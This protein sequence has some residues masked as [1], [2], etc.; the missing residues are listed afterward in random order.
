[1]LLNNDWKTDELAAKSIL[2]GKLVTWL[3]ESLFCICKNVIKQFLTIG[4]C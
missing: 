3:W 4:I 1:M 2:L